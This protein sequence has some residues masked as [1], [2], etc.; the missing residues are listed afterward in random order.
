MEGREEIK[1]IILIIYDITD[2]KHRRNL[3]KIL[4]SFGLRVQKS[5]FEA[6]LNKRQY[7][8]LLSKIEKFYRDSDNIRIYRLQE[9]EEV[10]V[11]GTEDYSAEEV[12]VI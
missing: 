4:S 12:I 6:R 5:A 8:K 9:Y 7:N 2:D 10:R 3:V 11:Y 1:Y